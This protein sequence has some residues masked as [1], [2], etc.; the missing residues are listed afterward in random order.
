MPN[1]DRPLL[2]T[3]RVAAA[4][5]LLACAASACQGEDPQPAPDSI[6][7]LGPPVWTPGVPEELF[8][9]IKVVD[10]DTIHIER[11]GKID[12]LRFLS[13]D[14]EE[15]IT[16]NSYSSRT[17]PQT[18]YGEECTHWAK[19]FFA[20]LAEEGTPPR[21]GILFP[22]GKEDLDIYGRLL[23]HVIL[24]DGRDFNLLLVEEGRS[25]YFNKYGN[26]R[27]CHAAFV[28][29]QHRARSAGIGIWD[30]ATNRAASPDA[31]SVRRPY[32]ELLPWWQARAEAIDLFRERRAATPLTLL[33]AE[34]AD[35][36]AAAM[37][38]ASA[39]TDA[40]HEIEV[41]CQIDRLFEE[42]NGDRTILFRATD[43]S[44]A[45]RARIPASLREAH[46]ALDLEGC[47]AEFRQNYLYLRGT[48]TPGPRGLEIIS[49]S[50]DQ[51]RAAGPEPAPAQP[52]F[53]KGTP[54]ESSQQPDGG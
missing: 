20:A 5:S 38:A 39:D 23:C 47:R 18:V 8:D 21:V 50:P 6:R 27:L 12:K 33:D 54:E 11:N 46:A 1:L 28:A 26:S 16:G 45:L 13:V 31:P 19:D 7:P 41:F 52:L 34:D 29:A 44:R 2:S 36:L 24:P 4:A 10:G 17:K 48:L 3:I 25:P 15:K 30:P 32:A 53:P 40:R 9:V 14:T 35:A 51:W 49:R 37:A 22:D 43:R 42:K